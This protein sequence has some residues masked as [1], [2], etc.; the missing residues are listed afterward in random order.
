MGN[1]TIR[2]LLVEDDAVDRIACRRALS[3]DPVHRFEVASA[4]TG[5]EAMRYL[6][7]HRVDCILLDYRLP[8]QTGLEFLG[9]LADGT[10]EVPLPVLVLTGED[11]TGVAVDMMRHGARDYLYKDTERRYLQALPA[12]IERMLRAQRL[13][14]DK[15]Q[16]EAMF[17][18]LVE[19]IQAIT[20]VRGLD[21]DGA[22]RYISP[23]VEALGFSA[24]EWLSDPGV[25]LAAIHP[26]DRAKAAAAIARSSADGSPLRVEYRMIGKNGRESWFRDEAEVVRDSTGRPLFQQ[27]ILIDITQS[28]LAEEALRESREALRRLAAHQENIKESERKRIAQE[29]HDELGGLLTGIKAHVSVSLERG[30]RAGAKADPLLE[31]AG[32]LTEDAIQAVRRVINDLRPSVLDQ[33]GVWEAIEWYSGQV[34]SRFGLVCD[35]SIAESALQA[36]VD[37]DRSI[38]LFRVVQESLTN[39]V[40]HADASLVSVHAAAKDD[41]VTVEV[42]DDGKGFAPDR[43][44]NH[45]SWGIQGMQE[46]TRHFGGQLTVSSI[47]GQGTR[48]SLRLPLEPHDAA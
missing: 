20:Y 11:S 29:I 33:L 17:R 41:V 14:E 21:G 5:D 15:R 48:V 27:G 13:V 2:V 1:T 45:H 35:C 44:A 40:R 36:R 37:P 46:R 25:P 26:A 39:V 4:E 30:V 32:R 12:A 10:G 9:S 19:Q 47:P 42:R 23:Q 24:E 6:Q 16:A 3:A 34:E 28:K 18:T 43:P 7:S 31:E 22:L 38:M 8:D